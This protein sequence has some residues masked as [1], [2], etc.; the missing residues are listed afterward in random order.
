MQLETSE[1]VIPD[2]T[3]PICQLCTLIYKQTTAKG[4]RKM[5][6]P[7]FSTNTAHN[8]MSAPLLLSSI[9]HRC[10]HAV[11]R[12]HQSCP[13]C[14]PVRSLHEF[15]CQMIMFMPLLRVIPHHAGPNCNCDFGAERNLEALFIIV[16]F[17]YVNCLV[18]CLIRSWLELGLQAAIESQ[19]M[20]GDHKTE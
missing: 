13:S 7:H 5:Q 14:A 6:E 2:H 16:L 4:H 9:Q 19:I 12:L 3:S 10:A 1:Y 20:L 18:K 15:Q 11:A 17:S 8:G